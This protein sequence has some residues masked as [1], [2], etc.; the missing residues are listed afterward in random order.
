MSSYKDKRLFLMAEPKSFL[1]PIR[2]LR[3]YRFE[4]YDGTD[5]CAMMVPI[6]R[7]YQK[8]DFSIIFLCILGVG[9]LFEIIYAI[10]DNDYEEKGRTLKF[11]FYGIIIACF[12]LLISFLNYEI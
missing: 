7:Y 12:I 3:W 2:A 6:R 1:V 4:C 8:I 10:E 11:L 5:S 9:I